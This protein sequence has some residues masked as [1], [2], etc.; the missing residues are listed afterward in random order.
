MRNTLC[1]YTAQGRL[2]CS[3]VGQQKVEEGYVNLPLPEGSYQ[4]T[5]RNCTFDGQVVQCLCQTKDSTK[6]IDPQSFNPTKRGFLSRL[7]P[8]GKPQQPNKLIQ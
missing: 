8:I 6:T 4:Q 3:K 2:L 1:Y 5:C 7:G